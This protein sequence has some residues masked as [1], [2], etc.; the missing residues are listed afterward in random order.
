MKIDHLPHSPAQAGVHPP[1]Q[2]GTHPRASQS[3]PG[4]TFNVTDT[5]GD[6][7]ETSAPGG[8]GRSQAS[9]AFLARQAVIDD[10]DLANLPFGHVVSQIARGV[11]GQENETV[12][13]GET[14]DTVGP[15]ETGD[16]GET[17]NTVGPGETGNTV[18]PGETGDTSETGDTGDTGDETSGD[19]STGDGTTA[20]TSGGSDSLIAELLDDLNDETDEAAT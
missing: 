16:T 17:G 8:P 3:A 2:A 11:F 4:E 14:G 10:P 12:G 15:G 6:T 20:T 9:P 7:A 5:P 13:P 1:A 19:G 18:G